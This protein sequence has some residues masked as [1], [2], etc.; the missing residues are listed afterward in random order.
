MFF[1]K[2]FLVYLIFV[3]INC[4]TPFVIIKALIA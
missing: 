4:K 1:F 2:Y 3:A